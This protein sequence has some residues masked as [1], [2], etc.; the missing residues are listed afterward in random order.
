MHG[1]RIY[2]LS[3]KFSETDGSHTDI[4][5]LRCTTTTTTTTITQ[6]SWIVAIFQQVMG[7][8]V[9]TLSDVQ[10]PDSNDCDKITTK[11]CLI[12]GRTRNWERVLE[13]QLVGQTLNSFYTIQT[14]VQQ[15]LESILMNI[16]VQSQKGG[17][18]SSSKS[19]MSSNKMIDLIQN[20]IQKRNSQNSI[21]SSISGRYD[22][23]KNSKRRP[24]VISVMGINGIGK[25]TTI[26]KLAYYFQQHQLTPLLVAGDTFRSGAIEQL[27]IHADCLNVPFYQQGYSKDPSSVAASAIVTRNG[28]TI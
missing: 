15:A 16:L 12:V 10:T 9:L 13:E 24:Y 27:R 25:T 18:G 7:T 23:T 6:S 4:D 5:I 8:K 19:S 28:T 2:P 20:V 21:W 11:E 22:G 1:W 14:A 17:G 26:A 3:K